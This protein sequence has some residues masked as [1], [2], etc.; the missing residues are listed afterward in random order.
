VNAI[1]GSHVVILGLNVTNARRK[2]LRGFA[3][4]RA[5]KTEGEVF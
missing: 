4:K 1:A 2:G 3:I 5:D